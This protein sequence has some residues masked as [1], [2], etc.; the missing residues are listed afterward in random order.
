[1]LIIFQFELAPLVNRHFQGSAELY[2]WAQVR[3]LAGPHSQRSGLWR[4]VSQPIPLCLCQGIGVFILLDSEPSTQS[5]VLSSWDQIIFI[6]KKTLF[7][8]PTTLTLVSLGDSFLT[9]LK[10]KHHTL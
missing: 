1:M 3:S 10:I 7:N 9:V 5:E 2:D 4:F 6:E 8:F